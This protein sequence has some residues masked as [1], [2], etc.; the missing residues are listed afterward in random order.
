MASGADEESRS[1]SWKGSDKLRLKIAQG[2][3]EKIFKEDEIIVPIRESQITISLCVQYISINPTFN[4]CLSTSGYVEVDF[5]NKKY[6]T[7]EINLR[8]SEWRL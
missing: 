7:N 2:S 8:C 3:N 5:T 1:A 4:H 6:E